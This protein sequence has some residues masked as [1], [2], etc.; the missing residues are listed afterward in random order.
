M[1]SD[2]VCTLRS[3]S[4][5]YIYHIHS[6]KPQGPVTLSSKMSDIVTSFL[7][8]DDF[9]DHEFN[10][11]FHKQT[12]EELFDRLVKAL[13][14]PSDVT[15]HLGNHL[16]MKSLILC[17]GPRLKLKIKSKTV[18]KSNSFIY[19][20]V[21]IVISIKCL[22][23]TTTLVSLIENPSQTLSNTGTV[24]RVLAPSLS[25]RCISTARTYLVLRFN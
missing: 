4:H 15:S 13:K 7:Y 24:Y 5:I 11:I 17:K 20:Y 22:R 10:F 2:Y 9:S 6:R 12:E 21:Y 1:W 18:F 19:M 3:L 23:T 14:I 16:I 25:V 8:S